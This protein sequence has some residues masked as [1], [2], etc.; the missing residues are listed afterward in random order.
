[1]I[2]EAYEAEVSDS[3]E[4]HRPQQIAH[5][6]DA[7]WSEVASTLDESGGTVQRVI[8]HSWRKILLMN[9]VEH[10]QKIGG[11][12][13]FLHEFVVRLQKDNNN[14]K[15]ESWL[16]LLLIGNK[17][18]VVMLH[19]VRFVVRVDPSKPKVCIIGALQSNV[20]PHS[21]SHVC[22]LESN[23]DQ[24]DDRVPPANW[25]DHAPVRLLLGVSV[26][27]HHSKAG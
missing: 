5:F 20:A 4:C 10:G 12:S 21:S 22:C 16:R 9:S 19:M 13:T 15:F 17:A 8:H 7:S 23:G 27:N 3:F 1:M 14:A 11:I 6:Q 25:S 26:P 18:M 2:K 24:E